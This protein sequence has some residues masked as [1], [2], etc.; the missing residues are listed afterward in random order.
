MKYDFCPNPPACR[1]TQSL[2]YIFAYVCLCRSLAP[3]WWKKNYSK[4]ILRFV[5]L[6]RV[7]KFDFNSR[8]LIR[9]SQN[10]KLFLYEIFKT[11]KFFLLSTKQKNNICCWCYLKWKLSF[12]SRFVL[13][14]GI[15]NHH[16]RRFVDVVIIYAGY[17]LL[18]KSLRNRTGND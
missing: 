4:N 7:G 11:E 12:S 16:R 5:C 18:R 2:I 13:C 1:F 17:I 10:V 6:W 8:L 15:Y 14:V 9:L 3:Q